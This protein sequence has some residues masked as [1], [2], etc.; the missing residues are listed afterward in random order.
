MSRVTQANAPSLRHYNLQMSPRVYEL[1][2]SSCLHFVRKSRVETA[3][4][5]K[6]V[7]L[8][9]FILVGSATCALC[10]NTAVPE[11]KSLYESHQWFALRDESKRVALPPFYHGAVDAA[12][13]D[14]PSA[15]KYLE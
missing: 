9:T 10:Q 2:K 5:F 1:Q 8:V 13:N 15:Q 11:L 14:L 7:C 6:C 3:F 4:A 12:F